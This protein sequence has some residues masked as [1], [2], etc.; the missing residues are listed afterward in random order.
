MKCLNFYVVQFTMVIFVDTHAI[1][2]GLVGSE[3]V[4]NMLLNLGG[5]F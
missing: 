5:T 2:L 4:D 1:V 3:R